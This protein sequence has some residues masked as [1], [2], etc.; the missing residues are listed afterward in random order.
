[1]ASR[2]AVATAAVGLIM[3]GLAFLLGGAAV[4]FQ[5]AAQS[6]QLPMPPG[7]PTNPDATIGIICMVIGAVIIASGISMQVLG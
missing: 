1:M 4:Y 6:S 5:R 2:R 3:V 7:L